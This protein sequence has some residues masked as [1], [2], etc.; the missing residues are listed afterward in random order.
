MSQHPNAKLTPKGRET[1]VSR[2][3]SGLGV[4]EAARQMGVS[5][6]TASKWLARARRGE[7]LADRSSRPRRL[8]RLTPPEVEE[9]ACE[10]RRAMLLAPFALAAETG[11]RAA[12][13]IDMTAAQAE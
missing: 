1:L 5:R 7:G 4:A 11:V 13:V 9:R 12:S 3:G 6:Q 10:A 8:A 2:I